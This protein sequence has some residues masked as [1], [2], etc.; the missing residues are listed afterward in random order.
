MKFT[1]FDFN[2]SE[3]ISFISEENYLKIFIK[4]WEEI[5][6]EFKFNQFCFFQYQIGDCLLKLEE[7]DQPNEFLDHHLKKLYEDVP[8]NHPF[9]Y[10]RLIDIYDTPLIEIISHTPEILERPNK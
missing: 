10:F 5:V 2:D 8:T 3:L 9:H 7:V 1:D 6:F 4:N